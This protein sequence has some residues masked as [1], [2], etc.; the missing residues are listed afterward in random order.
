MSRY[1]EEQALPTLVARIHQR[2][3][4]DLVQ[5]GCE[6]VKMIDHDVPLI[7]YFVCSYM[8]QLCCPDD[9][10]RQRTSMG[11]GIAQLAKVRD[12]IALTWRLKVVL[13][14]DQLD[15]IGETWTMYSE[16]SSALRTLSPSWLQDVKS[17][18][19]VADILNDPNVWAIKQRHWR[20]HF[21]RVMHS[22]QEDKII[23][24]A[25]GRFRYATKRPRSVRLAQFYGSQAQAMRTF[26]YAEDRVS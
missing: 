15:E 26:N 4:V 9:Y 7:S 23:L 2:M 24:P 25:A 20:Q 11:T 12:D 8:R 21:Q 13:L 6:P 10:T 1:T 17:I 14:N 3:R 22:H 18:R 5:W 16:L 19:R